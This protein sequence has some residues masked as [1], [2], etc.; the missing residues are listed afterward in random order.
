MEEVDNNDI[1]IKR[2]SVVRLKSGGP[3]MTVAI[4]RESKVWG[5]DWIKENGEPCTGTYY[6]YQLM[7][8]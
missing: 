5:C 3:A 2:G 8:H 7:I 1:R 4:E 6:E